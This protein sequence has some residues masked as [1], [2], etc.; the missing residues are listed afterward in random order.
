MCDFWLSTVAAE[1]HCLTRNRDVNG[2][3]CGF[4]VYYDDS[5]DLKS[6]RKPTNPMLKIVVTPSQE[7]PGVL[8]K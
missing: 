2:R 3:V 8:K 5:M 4:D 1:K 6:R 7:P